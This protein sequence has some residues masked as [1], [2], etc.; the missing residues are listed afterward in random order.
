MKKN[1]NKQKPVVLPVSLEKTIKDAEKKP[2]PN[3]CVVVDVISELMVMGHKEWARR[4]MSHK[5][6]TKNK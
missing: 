1:P 5:R 3:S 6:K 2:K 4:H